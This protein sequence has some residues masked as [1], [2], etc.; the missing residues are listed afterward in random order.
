VTTDTTIIEGVDIDEQEPVEQIAH[1]LDTVQAPPPLSLVVFGASGDLASR[2]LLPAIAALAEH[3]ALPAGFTV[4]GVARTT[5]T[6]KQ[7]RQAALD[8]APHAGPEWE[9]VVSR[10]RYVAGEYG[11]KPTFDKLK[12]VLDEADAQLGTGGNRVYYLAT[13]P[14]MFGTVASALAD[15]GC[16]LPGEQGTFARIVVEKP[17][18]R[19][20][21][22]ARA[23]DATLHAAFDESQ[24]FRIDHY[25]GKETVQNVLALRFGN[26]IFEPIWNRRYVD[27]IQIT[28]AEELGVEHRG[29]FYETAGAM[30]DIVQNHV[31]QVLAL[32]LMEP[33]ATVDALGIRDEKVKLLRAVMIPDVDAAVINSVRGQYAAG[34]IDGEPVI[35]YREEEGVDRHSRTETFVAMRLFVDNWRWAGVPVYIRTG[36]RL[37]K[38]AT[39]VV[40]QFQRVPHLAFGSQLTRD[41]RPNMLLLRIQPDEGICL[42]FGAKVPGEAFRLRSVDMDFNYADAFPGAEGGGY[43]RLLHDVMIGD[44]T[45]FIRTDE[46]ERAWQI[47]D[48]FLEAWGQDGVP[49]SQYPAGTWGP[50]E[51]DALLARDLRQWHEP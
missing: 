48:P 44:A 50:K 9:K 22:S 20:L 6:D 38:R 11:E 7:F 32:T 34:T 5:W 24:I 12:K 35:G 40:L 16:N 33:P 13:I 25:L 46:V 1:A 28:V 23:L 3:K 14:A 2:K 31:M 18:G 15:H 43:E 37:P 29:G 47:V 17:F 36:K 8:A 42:Y 21:E 4:V 39:E 41:L 49:L 26:A 51:S 27:H 30:R 19:D 10:F 45:L